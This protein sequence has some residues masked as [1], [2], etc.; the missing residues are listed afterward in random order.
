M[1]CI[2]DAD[3]YKLSSGR[4]AVYGFKYK[5]GFKDGNVVCAFPRLGVSK[6]LADG[7]YFLS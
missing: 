1:V 3:P 5:P 7:I 2:V 6:I 4:Y